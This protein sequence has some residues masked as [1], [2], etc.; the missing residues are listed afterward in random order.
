MY[1]YY[2]EKLTVWQGAKD[3]V[4]MTYKLTQKF[5][6]Q[7]MYGLT[8]QLQR[9]AVSVTANIAE[10]SS[11]STSKDQANFSTM[12]YAS[13]MEVLNLIII[14]L[15]LE[16]IDADEYVVFRQQIDMVANKIET[17]QKTVSKKGK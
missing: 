7:E 17:I 10:G 12:A 16:Y 6:K 4:V 15:E 2:F 8:S 3:L 14:A 11:R 9:A 13:L 1:Q 5:P